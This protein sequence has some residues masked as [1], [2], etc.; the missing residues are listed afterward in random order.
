MVGEEGTWP[1]SAT[2]P[3][4][5]ATAFSAAAGRR[6]GLEAAEEEAAAASLSASSRLYKGAGRCSTSSWNCCWNCW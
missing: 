2:T 5:A 1:A 3:E 4:T 6:P